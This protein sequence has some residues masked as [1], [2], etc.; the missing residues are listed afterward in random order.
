MRYVDATASAP[1][2][3]TTPST[4]STLNSVRSRSRSSATGSAASGS[5]AGTGRLAAQVS[6]SARATRVSHRASMV[7][8]ASAYRRSTGSALRKETV[9]CCARG[10]DSS[11]GISRHWRT[12]LP[13]PSQ[14]ARKVASTV[15]RRLVSP[16]T[17]VA[18]T[19]SGSSRRSAQVQPSRKSTNGWRRNASRLSSSSTGPGIRWY[20]STGAEP[21]FTVAYRWRISCTDGCRHTDIGGRSNPSFQTTSA[22]W[23]GS[24]PRART[25]R[26]RPSRRN[27]SMLRPL[28]YRPLRSSVFGC[29]AEAADRSTTMLRT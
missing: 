15:C 12:V 29:A 8:K 20:G 1:S 10:P 25:T 23:A 24:T 16:S 17:T 21:S 6:G 27:S 13:A 9:Q 11:S 5:S 14:A 26:A 19:P 4:W 28:R 7:R 18:T 22:R 3:C 2:H